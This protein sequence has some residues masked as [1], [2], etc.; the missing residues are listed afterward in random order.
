MKKSIY[1]VEN[2][3][4][5]KNKLTSRAGFVQRLY[6]EIA[7]DSIKDGLSADFLDLRNDY[8][9]YLKY[10]LSENI[11]N[12]SEA[13][14]KN[15]ENDIYLADFV[16]DAFND[17]KKLCKNSN[18]ISDEK[19]KNLKVKKGWESLHKKYH[20]H[21]TIIFNDFL[22]YLANF[23]KDKKILNFEHFVDFFVKYL[24]GVA[25]KTPVLKS[26]YLLSKDYSL[27]NTGFVVEIDNIKK[28]KDK[29][30]FKDYLGT[31]SFG[32]F[33]RL[34]HRTGF[35]IDK[36]C[37]WRLIYKVFSPE[38]EKYTKNY[39]IDQSNFI[40]EYFYKTQEFDI[41]N[42]KQYM[43]IFY[44]TF[45]Q[46]NPTA[47]NPKIITYNDKKITVNNLFD[48]K[49]VTKEQIDLK[50]KDLF[51][52]NIYCHISFV[53]NKVKLSNEQYK[54]ALKNLMQDFQSKGK[55]EAFKELKNFILNCDYLDSR[56]EY[57]FT[58]L[59]DT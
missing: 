48:R 43:I 15:V 7:F 50:Y 10:D 23:K 44:N 24:D 41:E 28:D 19:L 25:Y 16:V 51:W 57:N 26:S 5:G 55:M 1:I 53:E 18:T 37:P 38:A 2:L 36:D 27:S 21:L 35:A 33:V 34:C 9:Y 32:E 17:L 54:S 8:A 49:E 42:L 40:Q 12:I 20:D 14:L 3:P 29:D 39:N 22:K 45:V 31:Y 47:S 11:I 46:N 59:L 30:K 58:L 13:R 52:F 6:Y 56:G 4:N